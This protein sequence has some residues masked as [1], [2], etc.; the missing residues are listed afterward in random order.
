MGIFR[1]KRFALEH[2]RSTMKIGTDAI[3]LASLTDPQEANSL[4]DIGCGCGVITFC[5][6]QQIARR[7]PNPLICGVDPDNDSIQEA[8]ENAQN[9]TL[10]PPDCFHFYQTT[11]QAFVPEPSTQTFD[12]IVSNPPFFHQDLKPTIAGRR[13]S[14]HRDGQLSFEE[15]CQAVCERLKKNGRFALI[16]PLVEGAEF[17]TLAQQY[18]LYCHQRTIVKP[19]PQKPAHR[20]IQEYSKMEGT[21]SERTLLIRNEQNLYTEDYR[22]LVKPFLL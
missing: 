13:K 6:A 11:I 10:L 4:L 1:F 14:R 20:I 5:L 8:C 22:E 2:E 3:L 15:L 9:F 7:N 17:D 12:L 19:T 16:L 21:Y 18:G